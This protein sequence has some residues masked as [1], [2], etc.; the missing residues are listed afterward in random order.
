MAG[1]LDRFNAVYGPTSPALDFQVLANPSEAVEILGRAFVVLGA[2]TVSVVT[3]KGNTRTHDFEGGET[4][5][6]AIIEVLAATTATILVY[7]D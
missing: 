1:P 3:A 5:T 7:T 2:G 6:C 4:V